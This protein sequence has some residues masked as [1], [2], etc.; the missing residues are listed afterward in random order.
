MPEKTY[1]LNLEPEEEYELIGYV[2]NVVFPEGAYINNGTLFVYYGAA[3][4]YIALA[5]IGIDELLTEL[6]KHPA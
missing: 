3:D 5:K 2:N 1:L 6:D 4:R